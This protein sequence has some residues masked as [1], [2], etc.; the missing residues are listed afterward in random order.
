M[1]LRYTV[2]VDLNLIFTVKYDGSDRDFTFCCSDNE[3]I[4]KI[5]SQTLTEQFP[6]SKFNS[7]GKLSFTEN[8]DGSNIE[9]NCRMPITINGVAL[10]DRR[11][12][13]G[14]KIIL[15][16]LRLTYHS[17]ERPAMI[18]EIEKTA[19]FSFEFDWRTHPLRAAAVAVTIGAACIIA[20]CLAIPDR[21]ADKNTE[22]PAAGPLE[23]FREIYPETDISPLKTASYA[24]QTAAAP[25]NTDVEEDGGLIIIP[26]G[27]TVPELDLDILF[28]HAHPDDESLDFGCLLALAESAGL[29]TG[30]LTFTDG[31]SGLD[32]Y[33]DRPVTGIYPD[34]YME[35]SELAAVRSKE[36]EGAAGTLGVD[37]LIRLGLQNNPYNSIKDELP[38]EEIIDLW[39]GEELLT[40]RIIEVIEKTTP[41]TIAAPDAPGNAREHFEHEAVGYLAQHMM[42]GFS[43]DN[44]KAPKR[45]I[46]CIDPRQNNLYPEASVIDAAFSPSQGYELISLREV[47]IAALQMHKTQNDAVN[48]GTGF[49]PKYPAEYY[50]IQYWHSNQNWEEWIFSLSN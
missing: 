21:S 17:Y 39:G 10:T 40:Q 27:A 8:N 45:F 50:Q 6:K 5:F 13:P 28:I 19:P 4:W 48:M 24:P 23:T 47:Q 2:S 7:L 16:S 41:E 12:K 34:H 1:K 49:L 20:G 11:L 30:L 38:P 32:M 43:P 22:I 9:L 18:S 35:G 33:P 46:T 25:S 36:L 42:S 14:D 37:L 31:D 44:Y 29:K 3:D 15:G 26:P